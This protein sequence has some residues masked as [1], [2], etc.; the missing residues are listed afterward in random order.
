MFHRRPVIF[1]PAGTRAPGSDPASLRHYSTDLSD[2]CAARRFCHALPAVDETRSGEFAPLLLIPHPARLRQPEDPRSRSGT[3]PPPL[4]ATPSRPYHAAAMTTEDLR[5]YPRST[6]RTPGRLIFEWGELEGDI[7]NVGEG[8]LY[9]VTDTWEGPVAVGDSLT[10]VFLTP[11]SAEA[12]RRT[13]EV[14]RVERY[15]HEGELFRSFAI[16]FAEPAP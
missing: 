12:H 9:F 16:R 13:A 8:G 6:V 3:S 15:F 14:L 10:A 11:D 7:E 4:T 2:L 5:R 1:R